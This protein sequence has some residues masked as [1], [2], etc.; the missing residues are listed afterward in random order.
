MLDSNLSYLGH[1]IK[2]DTLIISVESKNKEVKCPFCGELSTR[3]HSIYHREFQDL[4]VMDKKVMIELNA[5]KMFC[6]NHECNH[7]TF[8]ERFNF[9]SYKARKSERL[10]HKILDVSASVS[11]VTA[12]E[13]ISEGTA[14]IGK[15]TI[16]SL[17]KKNASSCG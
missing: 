1:N 5:R 17:L 4:P 10:I 8:A 6:D 13:L 12:A 16:C 3:V 15:S 9:I 2:D 11:S 14:R 7:K